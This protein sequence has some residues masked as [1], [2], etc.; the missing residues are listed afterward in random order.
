MWVYDETE[1]KIIKREI[2]YVPGLFKIFDEIIVNAADN[3]QRDASMNTIKV[4]IDRFVTLLHF[5]FIF[6]AKTT[7]LVFGIM[8]K[9]FRLLNIKTRRCGCPK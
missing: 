1:G 5:A 8:V 7:R 4:K 9:V 3:K 6:A 2:S